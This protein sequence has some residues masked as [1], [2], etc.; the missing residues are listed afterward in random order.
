VLH[1]F[2]QGSGSRGQCFGGRFGKVQRVISRLAW[3]D[4]R[5]RLRSDLLRTIIGFLFCCG[6]AG[7]RGSAGFAQDDVGLLELAAAEGHQ[8]NPG[9]SSVR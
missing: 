2:R 9:L 5:R 4:R 6:G 3:R 1:H 8:T 7:V